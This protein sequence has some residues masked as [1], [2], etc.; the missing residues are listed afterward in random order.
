MPYRRNP[1]NPLTPAPNQV[2]NELNQANENFNILAQAFFNNDPATRVLKSDVYTFRRVDLT[3]A[4]SDYDMQVGEETI[5]NFTNRMS[6]PLRIATSSNRL[7][8]IYIHS[9][10]FVNTSYRLAPNNTFYNSSFSWVSITWSSDGPS[11]SYFSDNNDISFAMQGFVLCSLY[12]IIDTRSRI[13]QGFSGY[14]ATRLTRYSQFLSGW[15]STSVDWTLLG[16]LY[17]GSTST[18]YVL[19]RRLL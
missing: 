11:Y 19:I 4:T 1:F 6:V 10:G 7:Y 13:I 2:V 8:E 9:S 5:I 18:G 12:A 15:T 16:T 17:L 3:N 14:K